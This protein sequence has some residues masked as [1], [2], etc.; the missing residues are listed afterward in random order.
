MMISFNKKISSQEI[1]VMPDM[2]DK[3]QSI[4]KLMLMINS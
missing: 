4:S 2:K 3:F 1:M